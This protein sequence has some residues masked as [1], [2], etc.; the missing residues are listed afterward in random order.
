MEGR[1]IEDAERAD[2]ETAAS[3]V[4]KNMNIQASILPDTYNA[5][6]FAGCRGLDNNRILP[7]CSNARTSRAFLDS[8]L[9]SPDLA[10]YQR[11]KSSKASFL[12]SMNETLKRSSH[13]SA[14]TKM[15]QFL[16]L[17]VQFMRR[18]KSWSQ[19]AG[20]ESSSHP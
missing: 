3:R 12:C 16:L 13:S 15:P 18:Q 6:A 19:S 4:C 2:L 7:R 9:K 1:K 17:V 8:L 5:E 10:T 11:G 14:A 20:S